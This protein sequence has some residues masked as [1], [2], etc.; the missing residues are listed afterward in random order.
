M[1]TKHLLLYV[2]ACSLLLALVAGKALAHDDKPA[3]PAA[4]VPKV[5]FFYAELD[6]M[7]GKDVYVWQMPVYLK[8]DGRGSR[9]FYANGVELRVKNAPAEVL[10][11]MRAGEWPK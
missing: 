5:V 11:R 8:P 9:L 3:S 6:G 7:D 2:A 4:N 10:K 1:K